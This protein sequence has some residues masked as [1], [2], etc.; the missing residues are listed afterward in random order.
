MQQCSSRHRSGPRQQ[1]QALALLS[2]RSRALAQVLQQ[3]LRAQHRLLLSIRCRSF[4]SACR[5][6]SY[7]WQQ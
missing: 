4:V 6:W 3:E 1:L 2:S 7:S 5:R